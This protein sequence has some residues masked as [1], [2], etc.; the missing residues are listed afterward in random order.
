MRTSAMICPVIYPTIRLVSLTAL[1]TLALARASI[2]GEFPARSSSPE[3]VE[4]FGGAPIKVLNVN[5]VAAALELPVVTLPEIKAG[6]SVIG[7]IVRIC[8][9]VENAGEA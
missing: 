6:D 5:D 1:T 3:F 8:H 4:R 2:A 9:L 7:D